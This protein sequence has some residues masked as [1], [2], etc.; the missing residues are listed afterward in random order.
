MTEFCGIIGWP[1]SPIIGSKDDNCIRCKTSLINGIQQ[2]SDRLIH[3]QEHI[4]MGCRMLA[5]DGCSIHIRIRRRMWTMDCAEGCVHEKRLFWEILK[6]IIKKLNGFLYYDLVV[7][8]AVL[9]P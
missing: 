5:L 3:L 8:C 2:G 9:F 1:Y 6:M 7:G 4:H